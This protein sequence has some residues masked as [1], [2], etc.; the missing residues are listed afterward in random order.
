[1]SR[2]VVSQ[3]LNLPSSQLKE[4]EWQGEQRFRRRI[5]SGV[6]SGRSKGD[7]PSRACAG[8]ARPREAAGEV[9]T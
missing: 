2:A 8:L 4:S 3:Q 9:G 5:T 7:Q 6:E 1:M